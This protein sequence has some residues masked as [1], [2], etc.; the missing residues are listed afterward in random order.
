MKIMHLQL[1]MMRVNTPQGLTNST[2]KVA[3]LNKSLSKQVKRGP[4]PRT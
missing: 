3:H 1:Y 4:N 2:D